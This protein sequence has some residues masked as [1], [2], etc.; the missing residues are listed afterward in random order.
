MKM[1]KGRRVLLAVLNLYVQ[2]K[3]CVLTFIT[4]HSIIDIKQTI[5]HCFSPD[6]SWLCSQVSQQLAIDRVNV[7]GKTSGYRSVWGYQLIFCM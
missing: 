6:A 7:S 2:I 3:I 5:N 4:Y 1:C